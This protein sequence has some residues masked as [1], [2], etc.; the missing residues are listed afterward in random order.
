MTT[1]R[2]IIKLKQGLIS[3]DLPLAHKASVYL[4]ENYSSAIPLLKAELL[5]IH[6]EKI[7]K[8][9]ELRL[10]GGLLALL[11]IL[12]EKSSENLIKNALT[13]DLTPATLS[14]LNS[15]KRFSNNNYRRG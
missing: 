14:V 3:D 9:G 10:F 7:E 4:F 12:D 2:Y 6:L 1:E 5:K 8:A 15:T 11:R 13:M